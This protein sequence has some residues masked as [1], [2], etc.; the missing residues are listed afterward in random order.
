MQTDACT[1]L[2]T[3]TLKSNSRVPL[4]LVLLEE[5][6]LM[7]EE[8]IV[9]TVESLPPENHEVAHTILCEA[10]LL[11]KPVRSV[12]LLPCDETIH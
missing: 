10:G 6:H 3:L 7:S 4:G 12:L 1:M 2:Q 8:E 11:T 9:L 5:A